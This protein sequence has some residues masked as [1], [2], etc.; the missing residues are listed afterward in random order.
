MA[1][2]TRLDE[3]AQIVKLVRALKDRTCVTDEGNEFHG[4]IDE[5]IDKIED[6]YHEF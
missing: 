4:K 2:K 5:T 1:N 6:F 3:Q